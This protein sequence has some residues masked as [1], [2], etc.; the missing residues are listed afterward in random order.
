MNVTVRE[1]FS[2]ASYRINKQ[3]SKVVKHSYIVEGEQ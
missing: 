3:Q 1:L 2:Y